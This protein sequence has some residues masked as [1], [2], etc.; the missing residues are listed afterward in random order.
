MTVEEKKKDLARYR[1]K[2]ADESL[3]ETVEALL[4]TKELKKA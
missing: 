1:L 4:R 2:Q 3:D